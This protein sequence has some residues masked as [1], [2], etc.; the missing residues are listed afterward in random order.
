MFFLYC[1]RPNCE[2]LPV[3]V[4][5]QHL[6]RAVFLS[7]LFKISSATTRRT[8]KTVATSNPVFRLP[9][10]NS[11]MLPTIVGLTV[12]PRSPANA[13][14]ANIAVPPLGHF[15]E[16]ILIEPGHIIPTAKP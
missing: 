8:G 2:I 6:L 3:S 16:E 1:S 14:N 5:I 4:K 10:A 11:E 13:K 15:R 7:V 12:A 9:P